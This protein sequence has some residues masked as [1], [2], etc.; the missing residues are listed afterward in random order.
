MA[1]ADIGVFG[2]SGLY[3]LLDDV[4]THELTTPYG[5]PSAPLQIG[6]VGDRR[7]A[8]MARHGLAHEFPAHRVNY[9]ANVWAMQHAGVGAVLAPCSV[10][11]LRPELAPGHFV[12]VDQFVDRTSGR[13]DTFFDGPEPRHT[14]MAHPYDPALGRA[15][16]DA[17]RV[18]GVVVH[19]GG[20]V[21]VISGPR[22]STMA[23][24]RWFSQMGWHVVNMT[25]Y[26]EAPL[27]VEA[28]IRYGAVALVTDYDAGLEDD[29]SVEAVTQDQVFEFFKANISRVRSVL[30]RALEAVEL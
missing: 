19:E 3:E 23:E 24:S 4:E 6:V 9:R 30:F 15:I 16:A 8:F 2:G 13:A 5:A 22:F 25:Q 26:P 10:G 18:E 29:A 28:G 17:C 20:T 1:L 7:V 21:V 11:S 12:V 27:C 14:S